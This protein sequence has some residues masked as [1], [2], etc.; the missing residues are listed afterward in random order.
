MRAS[1]RRPIS[2][3]RDTEIQTPHTGNATS[4][5][6]CSGVSRR[7][8]KIAEG[9]HSCSHDVSAGRRIGKIIGH[10]PR[11]AAV[12]RS[13]DP[14]SNDVPRSLMR[15]ADRRTVVPAA[16]Q[17]N[18]V[19]ITRE[20]G[21]T[22]HSGCSRLVLRDAATRAPAAPAIL[23]GPAVEVSFPQAMARLIPDERDQCAVC[24]PLQVGPGTH[25]LDSYELLDPAHSQS[26]RSPVARSVARARWPCSTALLIMFSA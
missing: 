23:A 4:W 10:V 6:G 21:R 16:A 5:S 1:T 18:Q 2:G 24:Q 19:A 7:D 22:V 17:H 13:T 9:N 3:S 26:V 12:G 11:S 8:G 25:A 15:S 20:T 14:G